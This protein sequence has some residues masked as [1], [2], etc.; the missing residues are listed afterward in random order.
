[1][2]NTKYI[3]GGGLAGLVF[4]FYNRDYDLISPDLGGQL[5]MSFGPPKVVH[6]NEY[7]D[8]LLNNLGLKHEEKSIE[9][10]YVIDG[11]VCNTINNDIRRAFINKKMSEFTM[12]IRNSNV[13]DYTLSVD[14]SS[15]AYYDVSMKDIIAA[16][17]SKID[18]KVKIIDKKVILIGMNSRTL[19]LND[20]TNLKFT[21]IVSTI[22]AND[23]IHVTYDESY[24]KVLNYLP[25]TY[26]Y[27]KTLMEGFEPDP[28]ADWYYMC[29]RNVPFSRISKSGK[30][31]VYE[32]TGIMTKEMAESILN[33]V[34]IVDY[35]IQR[36]GVIETNPMQ[37]TN[38]VK[39]IGRLAEYKH[40]IKLQDIVRKCTT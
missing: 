10:R 40:H 30:N 37:D 25:V 4:A 17:K 13:L 12:P 15:L 11:N 6:A 28:E 27:S 26:V 35:S 31:W 7:T 20:Y 34:N 14:S 5:N 19:V 8:A 9:I 24:K 36:I 21:H 18:N 3:L 1:M 2:H 23:F 22:P 16:L 39:F 32:V 33:K 38:E 29:D